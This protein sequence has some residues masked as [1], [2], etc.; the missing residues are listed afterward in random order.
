[1]PPWNLDWIGGTGGDFGQHVMGWLFF[2]RARWAW[3]L[4]RIEGLAWPGG[5][6]VGFTDSNPFLALPGKLLSPLLPL[7]FQYVGAWLFACFALQGYV[8]ARLARLGSTAASHRALSGIL[9][10]VAPPLLARIGPG[11]R[12]DTLCA[13]FAL[14]ALLGLNLRPIP[15]RAH[16]R[17]SL[18]AA[19]AI[20]VLLGAVH[21]Y[22]AAMSMVLSVALAVRLAR[23]DRLLSAR[24]AC[25]ACVAILAALAALLGALGFMTEAPSHGGGFG[26]YSADLV[27]FLNPFDASWLV[28]Q[29]PG[30]YGQL[31]GNAYLGLGGLALLGVVAALAAARWRPGNARRRAL[32]PVFLAALA[33]AA[34]SLSDRVR[35]AGREVLDLRA[36]WHLL[37]GLVGPFRSSGRFIWPLYYLSLSGAVIGLPRLLPRRPRVALAMLAGAVALQFAELTPRAAGASFHDKRW[38][39]ASSAWQLARGRYDHLALVP[40]QVVGI[41]LAGACPGAAAGG[42]DW[43]P[44]AYEAYALG[45]TMNSAYLAR[46]AAERYRG[47]C[48]DLERE[49]AQGQL[50]DRTVYVVHPLLLP[51]LK[52]R[53]EIVCGQLDGYG[54]CVVGRDGDQFAAALAGEPQVE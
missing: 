17:R 44:F 46:G 27:T 50:R 23:T 54:V 40:P 16:A 51:A 4:G 31:E 24:E 11:I 32:A 35:L 7:D 28:P 22:L 38:R 13:H 5:T 2:R 37:G 21:P 39:L 34:F 52:G 20:A 12:H 43:L 14:L 3:P 8:G 53:G 49:V 1:L 18:A 19:G 6:T 42:F 47:A 36:F 29:L 33:M 30:S 9:F 41:G 25:L 15:N 10:A 45:M 26:I 48:R